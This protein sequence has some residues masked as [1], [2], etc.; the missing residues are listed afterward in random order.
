MIRVYS[1]RN[2]SVCGRKQKVYD[3]RFSAADLNRR[4]LKMMSSVIGVVMVFTV[5]AGFILG[6]IN[7]SQQSVLEREMRLHS[8]LKQANDLLL[9]ERNGMLREER[10]AVNAAKLGLFPSPENQ[11]RKAL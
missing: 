5:I 1:G 8:D 2:S 11:V 4:S 9:A 7:S 10:I 3:R 6:Q